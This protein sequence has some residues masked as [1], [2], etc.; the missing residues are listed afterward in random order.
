MQKKEK[1]SLPG[2][3]DGRTGGRREKEEGT[4]KQGLLP[5]IVPL[6][7]PP[8]P[9]TK[10]H[11]TPFRG[12][13]QHF[14]LLPH[15]RGLHKLAQHGSA[16]IDGLA[17]SERFL[18][19]CARPVRRRE[20]C[21]LRWRRG[22][23]SVTLPLL[24]PPRFHPFS[25]DPPSSGAPSGFC[26]DRWPVASLEVGLCRVQHAHSHR[27]FTVFYEGEYS[28]IVLERSF[29]CGSPTLYPSSHP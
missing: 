14:Q 22:L 26:A 7:I 16:H 3:R 18:A 29:L 23:R 11:L 8:P 28:N 15:T 19:P 20:I 17:H 4:E 21:P 12:S 13:A 1:E 9:H 24:L 27:V 5:G 10:K 6:L 25:M 2:S